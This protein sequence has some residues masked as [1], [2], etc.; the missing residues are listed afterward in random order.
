MS[1]SLSRGS[2]PAGHVE[3]I[4][5]GWGRTEIRA[6]PA[7]S[8]GDPAYR[9]PAELLSAVLACDWA[10]DIAADGEAEPASAAFTLV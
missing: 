6:A 3:A 8:A 2:P 9:P 1:H 10:A 7:L 5:Q 4:A